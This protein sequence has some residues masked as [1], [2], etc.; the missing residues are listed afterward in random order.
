M[1][2]IFIF[3]TSLFLNANAIAQLPA[4]AI[5]KMGANPIWLIDS[6]ETEI[7]LVEKLNPYEIS[8]ISIVQP[9]KAKKILGDKGAD[10]A[11][12]VTTVNAAKNTYWKFFKSKSQE[13]RELIK[14]PQ[15]DTI[16]QYLLNG[17][18]LSDS[19][20]PGSLFLINDKNFKSLQIIDKEKLLSDNVIPKRYVIVITA[21]KPK[22]FVKTNASK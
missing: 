16:A 7:A 4:N 8:N 18:L 21:K 12:Y 17:V 20:A 9:K 6:I 14:S 13:Y 15:A 11:I 1:K 3:L 22:G 19:A 2:I 10:G 5:K